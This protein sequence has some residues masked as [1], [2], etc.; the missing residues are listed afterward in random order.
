MGDS[1]R[2]VGRRR[3]NGWLRIAATQAALLVGAA[4][5]VGAFAAWTRSLRAAEGA[6]VTPEEVTTVVA[7]LDRELNE[8]RGELEV[9]RLQLER[10]TN[11]L[12]YSAKYRI[13]ADLSELIYDVAIAEGIHPSLG[14]QLVKV[15][16]SFR[17]SA[18][19]A[20]GA[21]GYTQIRLRTARAYRPDVTEGQ[22]HEPELNLRL[23]FRFLKDLLHRFD[24]DLSLALSAY[25]RG[26]TLVDSLRVTGE[27][28]S[29]GYSDAV[30]RGLG[31]SV[32]TSPQKIRQ[33]S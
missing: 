26:P 28:P 8:A 20:K 25:N 19:S 18:R 16:S 27:D 10:A 9:T 4:L 12:K 1:W 5:V 33:G 17:P 2:K 21:I 13:P 32:R 31:P 3:R 24:N 14:F 23:G 7:S 15:E 22:L 11:I 6:A 29:N 30:M